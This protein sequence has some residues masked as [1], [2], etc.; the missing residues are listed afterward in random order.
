MGNPKILGY[1]IAFQAVWIDIWQS[2]NCNNISHLEYLPGGFFISG[3]Q[4]DIYMCRT[5]ELTSHEP[6]NQEEAM[7][8]REKINLLTKAL[9]P[10]A[11]YFGFITIP[12]FLNSVSSGPIAWKDQG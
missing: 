7:K 5:N 11:I 10:V 2:L 8:A 6:L 4:L 1:F 9:I 3:T 12:L